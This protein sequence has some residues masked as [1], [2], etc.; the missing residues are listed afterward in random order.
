MKNSTQ[1]FEMALQINKPWHITSA[2]LTKS[3]LV[4]KLCELGMDIFSE[5]FTEDKFIKIIS[6]YKNKMVGLLLIDQHIISGIGNYLR[7]DI[8]Y[9]A[10][11]HPNTKI[12]ELSK[13]ELKILYSSIKKITNKSYEQNGTNVETYI[14]GDYDPLVYGKKFDLYGNKVEKLLISGRS[15][16]YVPKIQKL[17]K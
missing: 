4:V 16:Y 9:D 1:I 8:L 5:K 12:N 3:E 11:I 15:I 6:D 2:T 17:K 14:S 13:D 10:K 7:A